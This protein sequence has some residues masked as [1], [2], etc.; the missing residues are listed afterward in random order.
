[1]TPAPRAAVRDGAA[2][3]ATAR[4]TTLPA[5]TAFLRQVLR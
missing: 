3:T 4:A 1:M 5:V 2:R